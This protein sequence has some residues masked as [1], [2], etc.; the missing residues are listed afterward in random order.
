MNGQ[1]VCQKAFFK[2]YGI[3]HKKWA[4]ALKGG[5]HESEGHRSLSEKGAHLQ[6]WLILWAKHNCDI[7]PFSGD[8]HIMKWFKWRDVWEEYVSGINCIVI[9]FLINLDCKTESKPYLEKKQFNR[10]R[11]E[12]LPGLKKIRANNQQRCETCWRNIEERNKPS[13][14]ALDRAKLKQKFE[15][16]QLLQKKE[17]I[18]YHIRR[19]ECRDPS[20]ST[21]CIAIDHASKRRVYNQFPRHKGMILDDFLELSPGSIKLSFNNFDQDR[22][23]DKSFNR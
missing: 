16:H 15:E 1:N 13:T 20:R 9:S 3:S 21:K 22:C 2:T 7:D 4:N 5:H 12:Y 18:Q 11:K 8:L 19:R 14:S 10:I 17:R 23:I 6:A